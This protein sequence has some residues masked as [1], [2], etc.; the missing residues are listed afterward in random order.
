MKRKSC[1]QDESNLPSIRTL[2]N[3]IM[4]YSV[5]RRAHVFLAPPPKCVRH[6]LAVP[7]LTPPDLA[8][9]LPLGR[10]LQQTIDILDGRFGSDAESEAWD[11]VEPELVFVPRAPAPHRPGAPASHRCPCHRWCEFEDKNF[12][13]GWLPRACDAIERLQPTAT[14]SPRHHS[15]M[16]ALLATLRRWGKD[17][18][19]HR[20]HTCLT[21]VDLEALTSTCVETRACANPHDV[22][23]NNT[24]T[25]Y[26]RELFAFVLDPDGTVAKVR[27]LLQ[28][29]HTRRDVAVIDHL[30]ALVRK[31]AILLTPS[32]G[33]CAYRLVTQQEAACQRDG[34]RVPFRAATIIGKTWIMFSLHP[35]GATHQD[36]ASHKSCELAPVLPAL[37][38]YTYLHS[39]QGACVPLWTFVGLIAEY[40]C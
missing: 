16:I 6:S 26:L 37:V 2:R 7:E 34:T 3:E 29:S 24:T 11:V 33:G 9:A 17:L 25:Q 35:F 20:H 10:S 5:E 30:V 39:P 40:L 14:S 23:N 8:V 4:R 36:N 1:E 13:R 22:N 38:L 18:Q 15:F 27:A 12:L 31:A 21:Q 19:S 28:R 32:G